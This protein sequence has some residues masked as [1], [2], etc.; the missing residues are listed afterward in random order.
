MIRGACA[1]DVRSA[2]RWYE[3]QRAGLG[4]EFLQSFVRTLAVI[5]EHPLRCRVRGASLRHAL[6]RRF[7]YRV[8]YR[9]VGDE[10]IVVACFHAHRD[11]DVWT[12]RQ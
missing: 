9:L 7:P 4:E 8:V 11:P 1:Q 2:F 10:V 3:Q 12:S 6:T 5:R